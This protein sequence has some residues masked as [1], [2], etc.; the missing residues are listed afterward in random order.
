M[1]LIDKLKDLHQFLEDQ[2]SEVNTL[3]YPEPW[4]RGWQRAHRAILLK[5]S[6]M[7]EECDESSE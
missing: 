6:L 3:P 5:V 1:K 7:I 4:D 2:I